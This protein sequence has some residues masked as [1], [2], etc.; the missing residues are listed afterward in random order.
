MK[1]KYIVAMA[2][3]ALL[4]LSAF[5]LI[6]VPSVHASDTY[7]F[8]T[9]W[10]G[11]GTGD[12]QFNR[13]EGM[14]VDAL[15]NLYVADSYNNRVQK[16]D[17]G[18]T[19][20]ATWG[21]YGP[22]DG[23]FGYP[24]SVALD[25][26]GNVIIMDSGYEWGNDHVQTYSDQGAF[27]S[28][29]GSLYHAES[30]A[31]DSADN[32]Y[33]SFIGGYI[34]KYDNVG[35]HITS[36]AASDDLGSAFGYRLTVGPSDHVFVSDSYLSCVHEFTAD[37]AAV[38]TWGT[39]G[40]EDGQLLSPQG[41][42][43]D[44]A[45]N[46]YVADAGNHRVQKFTADGVLI[47]KWGSGGTGEGQFG[48]PTNIVVD[49]DGNVFVSDVGTGHIL[50]FAPSDALPPV[51][52][53]IVPANGAVNVA[54]STDIRV[55]FSRAM[56]TATVE[57]AFVLSQDG[58]MIITG[59]FAWNSGNTVLTFTPSA[60]LADGT[61]YN[62]SVGMGTQDEGGMAMASTFLSH[63]T[64]GAG[65]DTVPPVIT[66]HCPSSDFTV[67]AYGSCTRVMFRASYCDN[68]GVTSVAIT[69]DGVD[70][71]DAWS[72]GLDCLYYGTMLAPGTHSICLTVADAAG[73]QAHLGWKVTVV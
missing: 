16:F 38:R 42:A 62:I 50:K 9:S 3:A 4:L 39:E 64:V 70:V 11:E 2:I 5:V 29:W 37:G 12:G 68:V 57:G 15:G 32:V 24:M 47:T 30:M 60:A 66:C 54:A 40:R 63:F 56:D 25:S 10:G 45:G 13:P 8:V 21:S 17:S 27:I 23:Q 19:F 58:G 28:K 49:D 71:T 51:V 20:I 31:L 22:D 36:W 69:V 67:C 53:G 14:A 18:G 48:G 55:T 6:T 1:P 59:G 65:G 34:D 35:N 26:A 73:N 33:I 61:L 52:T 7:Q 41:I 44:S 43:V 72:P 46:V